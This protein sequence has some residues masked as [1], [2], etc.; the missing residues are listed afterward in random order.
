[1]TKESDNVNL[2]ELMRVDPDSLRMLQYKAYKAHVCGI[3]HKVLD[4][5]DSDNV[6]AIKGL[7][8][9]M[10]HSPAGDG[11]GEDNWCLNFGV[12]GAGDGMDNMDVMGACAKLLSLLT[13]RGW[14]E[15]GGELTQHDNA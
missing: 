6:E 12:A 7:T 11:W 15:S 4:A 1:M 8:G 13:G 2:A 9:L 10:M 5:I 3:L 14:Q